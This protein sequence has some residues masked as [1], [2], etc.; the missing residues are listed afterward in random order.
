MLARINTGQRQAVIA[1][2]LEVLAATACGPPYSPC[3]R[4][5]PSERTRATLGRLADDLEEL[6]PEAQALRD[7][8]V[9]DR[10]LDKSGTTAARA[11]A[12]PITRQVATAAEDHL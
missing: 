7:G 4:C 1:R 3:A 12:L 6:L 11:A 8:R 2:A 9:S 10:A 5:T